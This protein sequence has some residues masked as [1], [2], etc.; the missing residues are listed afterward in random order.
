MANKQN[1]SAFFYGIAGTVTA[2]II[3]WGVKSVFPTVWSWI[4]TPT[5]SSGAVVAF[6]TKT[7]PTGW[8]IFEDTEGR[9]ILGWSED[10]KLPAQ[11]TRALKAYYAQGGASNISLTE[12]H[13]PAHNHGLVATL[14]G[15]DALNWSDKTGEELVPTS[16]ANHSFAHDFSYG[17]ADMEPVSLMPPYI[18]LT[19]CKKK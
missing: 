3:L 1:I 8:D 9:F 12:D 4:V 17:S 16:F 2:G 14:N 19:Y 7:C 13:L 11:E 15:G 5:I 18:A 6:T 10:T